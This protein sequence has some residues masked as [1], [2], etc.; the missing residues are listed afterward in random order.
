MIEA[1]LPSLLV[2]GTCLEYGK[3]SGKLDESM[4]R[5]PDTSY[6]IAKSELLARLLALSEHTPGFTAGDFSTFSA[7]GKA[8]VPG[9]S[10]QP[11]AKRFNM[12]GGELAIFCLSNI[13]VT[14][15]I[16]RKR[17]PAQVSSMRSGKPIAVR[18]LVE[19][20]SRYGLA[21]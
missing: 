8:K 7:T 16:L 14:W 21:G 11:G 20:G 18:Q 9:D 13:G 1:G 19:T 2:T 15:S 10:T 12:S 3:Q 17:T 5:L 6:A 4:T